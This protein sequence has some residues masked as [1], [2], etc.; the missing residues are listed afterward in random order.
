MGLGNLV[1][2]ILSNALLLAGLLMVVF[3]IVGGIGVISGA[4]NDNPEKAGQGRQAV[5]FGLIGF[6]VVFAAYW[7]IQ[8][9]EQVTGVNIFNPGF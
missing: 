9:I 1:S 8:I 4:G 6:L 3:L 2:I 5:T 7:I